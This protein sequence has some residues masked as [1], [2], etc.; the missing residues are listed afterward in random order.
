MNSRIKKRKLNIDFQKEKEIIPNIFNGIHFFFIKYN[1]GSKQ[2]NI[3]KKNIE[4][5][6]Y[7]K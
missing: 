1:I 3:L 6:G 2:F 7:L 5:R 4:K